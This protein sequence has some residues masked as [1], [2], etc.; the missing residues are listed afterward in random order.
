MFVST[1]SS[2]LSYKLRN[3]V[4]A[5]SNLFLMA[6]LGKP[7]RF[8]SPCQD[9]TNEHVADVLMDTSRML[10]IAQCGFET[11]QSFWYPFDG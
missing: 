5:R 2:H 6:L 3:N 9:S 7:L 1:N 10:G 8:A 11:P 4:T